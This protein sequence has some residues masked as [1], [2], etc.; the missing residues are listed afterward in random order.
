MPVRHARRP[1]LIA[2]LKRLV[3]GLE[4]HQDPASWRWFQVVDRGGNPA[5][6]VETSCSAMHAYTLSRA[7]E[8]GWLGLAHQ[9]PAGQAYQSV[10]E[11][12][13]IDP[14]GL[15]RI[16]RIVVGTSVG[17]LAYYLARPRRRDDFHGL[18]AFLIMQDQFARL[19]AWAGWHRIEAEA[20]TLAA[21]LAAQPQANAS[22]G[23]VVAR[24]AGPSSTSAPGVGR[25]T[26][27]LHLAK[28]GRYKL[29]GRFMAT[30]EARNSFWVRIDNGP[31]R[32]WNVVP[33][34]RP[35]WMP[36]RAG[37]GALALPVLL[38]LAAGPH[39]L[40]LADAEPGTRLDALLLTAARH[41][42]PSGPGG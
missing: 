38:D 18:G 40:E 1:E 19:P 15:A 42:V 24:L 21:P 30:T 36:L 25:A 41:Y 3:L 13:S 17:D 29:W 2:I 28:P 27:R 37:S 31:W 22:G 33:H 5:N 9:G 12:A 4:R 23:T 34:A 16:D 11:A 8:R 14:D 20:G 10:L 39:L 32:L 6:W 35:H 26:Y 7:V